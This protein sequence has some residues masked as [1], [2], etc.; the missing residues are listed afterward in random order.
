MTI[1]P[2]FIIIGVMKGGTSSLHDR[3]SQ[4][5]S[6]YMSQIKEPNFYLKERKEYYE[7]L[8]NIEIEIQKFNPSIYKEEDYRNLFDKNKVSG[9]SSVSYFTHIKE[10]DLL[11]DNKDR[12]IILLLRDP[13]TRLFSDY[14]MGIRSGLIK[15]SFEEFLNEKR[16]FK[17]ITTKEMCFYYENI[18]HIIEN[19]P[20]KQRLILFFEEF[21]ENE[22]ITLNK[23][24]D[25]L[26]VERFEPKD[27]TIKNKGYKIKHK[28]FSLYFKI[29]RDYKIK[30][31][32]KK[33]ISKDSLIGKSLI[34]LE[35][36]FLSLITKKEEDNK[37]HIKMLRD[38][39]KEDVEK[40]KSILK[41]NG[42]DISHMEKWL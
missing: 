40:T 12:K 34:K 18:K 11:K 28:Y 42:I 17:N 19:Y 30:Q 27:K 20:E 22:Q 38:I 37:V 25:F 32:I 14:N 21:A 26:N 41:E 1:K 3:L 31:K 10:I 9:E 5:H 2:D 7:K 36:V 24:T 23:I 29:L 39:Y 13:I 6:L 15:S 35:K 8:F 16:G 33:V 4:H